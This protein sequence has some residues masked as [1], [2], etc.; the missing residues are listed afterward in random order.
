MIIVKQ[1][2]KVALSG[3]VGI[4][5]ISGSANAWEPERNVEFV[6]PY[7]AGGGSDINARMLVETFRQSDLVDE[8]ILVNNRPGGSGA[9]G[10]S[11]TY[12]KGDDNH[13]I[14]T[15][16]GGQMMSMVTMTPMFSWKT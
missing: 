16:N 7:S 4:T 14:M 15:F 10:N 6:V 13:T 8:T 2:S 5:L 9:V 1:L 3:A 11:Y 12:N